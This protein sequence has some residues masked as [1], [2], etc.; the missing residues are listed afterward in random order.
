MTIGVLTVNAMLDIALGAGPLWFVPTDDANVEIAPRQHIT[1]GAASAGV[2]TSSSAHIFELS[3]A[4]DVTKF[5]IFD[6]A[7]NGNFVWD[8][9]LTRP[10]A[11]GVGD[12]LSIGIGA[13]THTIT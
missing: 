13:I 11:A 3:I 1:Y 8:G 2:K 7:T 5:R 6:A 10:A 9:L 12:R 4:M